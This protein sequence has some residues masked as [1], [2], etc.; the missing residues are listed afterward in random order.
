MDT[1]TSNSGRR[2]R[3]R[4]SGYEG[5]RDDLV[6]AHPQHARFLQDRWYHHLTTSQRAADR[7]RNWVYV[8]RFVSVAGLALL[9]AIVTLQ[10]SHPLSLAL[11]SLA[12]VT[13][14][15]VALS[16]GVLSIARVHERWRLS[17]GL[18]EKLGRAGWDL[19][20]CPA[21]FAVFHA[22]V[23]RDLAAAELVYQSSVAAVAAPVGEDGAE[24]RGG[25]RP[26]GL[27]PVIA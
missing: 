18:Q 12:I 10:G 9:P 1:V 4:R 23:E 21:S 6:A 2:G 19:I 16:G 17:H 26:T 22:T 7:A 13:S 3:A 15:L 27:T 24:R 11:Q 5:L 8:S 14:V 25:E 20:H